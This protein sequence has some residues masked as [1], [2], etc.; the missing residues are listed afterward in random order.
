MR[1]I[2]I[3]QLRLKTQT[4]Q[5]IIHSILCLSNV[6]HV[7]GC[8]Y[9]SDMRLNS[10]FIPKGKIFLV[11]YYEMWSSAPHFKVLHVKFMLYMLQNIG[12]G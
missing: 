10:R 5:S 11:N 8:E 6:V 7:H 12:G 1:F 2:V 3:K 9:S 4:I